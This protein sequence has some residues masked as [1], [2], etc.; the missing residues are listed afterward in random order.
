MKK[1]DEVKT[2]L[3]E[4]V[5]IDYREKHPKL[6]KGLGCLEGEYEIKLKSDAESFDLFTPRRIPIPLLLKV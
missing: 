1:V 2:L 6:F 4:K 5:R 3:N